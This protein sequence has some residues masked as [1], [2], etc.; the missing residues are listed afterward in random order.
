MTKVIKPAGSLAGV[1]LAGGKVLRGPLP[2]ALLS[3]HRGSRTAPPANLGN[4]LSDENENLSLEFFCFV[5]VFHSKQF[6]TI[7]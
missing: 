7:H 6:L 4:P 5:F 3:D 2:G 1:R